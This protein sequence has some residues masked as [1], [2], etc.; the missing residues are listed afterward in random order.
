M[1]RPRKTKRNIPPYVYCAKGRWF[2]REYLGSGKFGKETRLASEGASDT[3]IWNAYLELIG[4]ADKTGSL[5]WLISEYFRSPY[6]ERR[7]VSTK[8]EYQRYARRISQTALKKGSTF[9]AVQIRRITPGVIRKYMDKRAID[10][11]VM[12]NREL[13]FLSVVFGYG[14]ERDY[15]RRNPAKGVKPQP[16]F[17]KKRL[18]T[19]EEYFAVYNR[20]SDY[21]QIVMELQYLCRL[22]KAEVIGPDPRNVDPTRPLGY[23]GLKRKHLLDE[24]L[25][26]VR[27]KESKEQIIEWSP[28]LRKA[29]DRAKAL[30]GPA[31]TSFLLHNRQGQQIRMSA[32]NSAFAR[33]RK[34]A[35]EETGI[36][37]FSLHD[38]KAKGVSDFDGDKF[39]ATGNKSPHMVAVYDRGIETVS[40]T[41]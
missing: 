7:A 23:E 6:F 17:A 2:H 41:K 32:L 15:V 35:M 21:V 38:L 26:V 33:A 11:P 22:R 9:G 3:Y 1:S 37:S 5:E 20:A 13:E 34:K 25:H 10:A 4:T 36:E 29:I 19:D 18:V 30:P 12:A 16:E 27:A 8:R 39:K 28:R 31:S 14:F 24:G 40:S